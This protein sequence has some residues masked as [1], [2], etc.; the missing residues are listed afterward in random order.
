MQFSR[1]CHLSLLGNYMFPMCMCVPCARGTKRGADGGKV[2]GDGGAPWRPSDVCAACVRRRLGPTGTATTKNSRVRPELPRR[3]AD[4]G[5]T[6]RCAKKPR[7]KSTLGK[8]AR[9]ALRMATAAA[10]PTRVL[11]CQCVVV[12]QSPDLR[13]MSVG[14]RR[15]EAQYARSF[16][17]VDKRRADLRRPIILRN[18]RKTALKPSTS[19][20]V[21]T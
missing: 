3:H 6:L 19:C 11:P 10:Q 14:T 15:N 17:L 21:S 18:R 1:T 8:P 2:R 13:W 5:R 4:D 20:R 12:A 7:L 16:C 9:S